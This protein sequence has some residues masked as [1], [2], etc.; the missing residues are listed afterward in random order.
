[1][2]NNHNPYEPPIATQSDVP[3]KLVSRGPSVRVGIVLTVALT[4][5]YWTWESQAGGNIRVDLL[6]AYPLLF[7]LYLY[8]LQRLGWLS[9]LIAVGLMAINYFFFT[10]SYS[11]FDKPLG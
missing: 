2:I 3:S 6:M 11:L 1:M 7:G 9:A 8:A 4:L 10:I 5:T